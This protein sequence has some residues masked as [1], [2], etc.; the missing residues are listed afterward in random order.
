MTTFTTHRRVPGI[1]A[2]REHRGGRDR[3][4]EPRSPLRGVRELLADLAREVPR[5][6]HDDV[7]L[8]LRDPLGRM[9]RDVRSRR[10]LALLVG[11]P[12]DRVVEEVRADPA[13]V[14]KRVALARRAVADDLL[15]VAPEPDQEVEERPLRL[16]HALREPAV[17]RRV[18]HPLDV[19]AVE[20]LG[21]GRARLDPPPRGARKTRSDPPWLGSSSTSTRSRPWAPKIE[22]IEWS[23]KYEKCS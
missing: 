15:P 10:V 8:G 20:E 13:V 6:D 18:A 11:V 21:D 9:D 4:D 12:V 14:E 7:G 19:L 16:A 3:H 17:R 1:V 22:R 23:E 2:R 5:Q